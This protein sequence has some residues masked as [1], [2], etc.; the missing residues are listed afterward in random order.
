[1]ITLPLRFDLT[2]KGK[3]VERADLGTSGYSENVEY[4]LFTENTDEGLRI[5]YYG[6]DDTWMDLDEYFSKIKL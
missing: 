3:I 2:P 6:E 1:M 5:S 4:E